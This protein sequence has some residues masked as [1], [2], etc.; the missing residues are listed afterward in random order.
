M[1]AR[2]FGVGRTSSCLSDEWSMLNNIGGLA[3]TER[4]VTAFAQEINPSLISFSRTAATV[5]FPIAYGVT[6]LSLFRFGDDLYSEQMISLG[7]ANTFGITSIGVKLNYVQYKVDGFGRKGMFSI[8]AGGITKLTKKILIGTYI[9]N[10]NQPKLSNT[11]REY[12]PTII[13]AGLGVYVSETIFITTE[14]EKDLGFDP[15]WKTG[16]EYSINKKFKARTGVNINPDAFFAGCGF[17][18]NKFKLD[19]AFQ[20]NPFLGN[21]HQASAAYFFKR[22][23]E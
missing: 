3:N 21:S 10:I 7:F 13:T 18:L 11:D 9:T 22:K 20:Y 5:A 17:V 12:L 2:A 4:P 15:T 6:G 14:I 19:Y 1:G 8:S 23:K 16:M